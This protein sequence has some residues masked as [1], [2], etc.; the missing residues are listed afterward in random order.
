MNNFVFKVERV[1]SEGLKLV[2]IPTS[3]Q[4][5]Q[6]IIEGGLVLS[7]L[8]R[9]HAIDVAIDGADE[10]DVS[11]AKKNQTKTTKNQKT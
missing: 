7:D 9:H 8:S 2:C 6:L 1:K 10:V 11:S 5:R 4:A 3:F